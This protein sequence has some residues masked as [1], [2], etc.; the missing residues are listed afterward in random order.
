MLQPE[1]SGLGPAREDLEWK[2]ISLSA[3]H[4]GDVKYIMAYASSGPMLQYFF[5]TTD[6]HVS[7]PLQ[8]N[9]DVTP[10]SLLVNSCPLKSRLQPEVPLQVHPLDLVFDFRLQADRVE[11]YLVVLNLYKLLLSLKQLLPSSSHLRPEQVWDSRPDTETEIMYIPSTSK[12][13]ARSVY[14]IE[15]PK[16][17]CNEPA[18]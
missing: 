12:H 17:W 7:K 15:Q 5:I 2:S 1:A 14:M 9:L 6:G 8:Q 3:T 10:A 18:A 16:Q 11:H 4:Y 13:N